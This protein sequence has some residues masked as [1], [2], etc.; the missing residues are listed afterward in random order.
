MGDILDLDNLRYFF[1]FPGGT[2]SLTSFGAMGYPWKILQVCRP[3]VMLMETR[4]KALRGRKGGGDWMT[5]S[6]DP[7][8]LGDVQRF[9]QFVTLLRGK[10]FARGESI[11]LTSCN[12]LRYFSARSRYWEAV[13]ATQASEAGYK[14]LSV[15]GTHW[16]RTKEICVAA[17]PFQ[18]CDVPYNLSSHILDC[19]RSLVTRGA[20]IM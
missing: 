19:R 18:S 6:D 2:N 9:S 20:S 4:G 17:Y 13:I 7:E 16:C 10:L 1:L 3:G 11:N 8:S 12:S 5:D 14:I 15:L